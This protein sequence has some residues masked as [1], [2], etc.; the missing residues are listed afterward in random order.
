VLGAF[1]AA[2]LGDTVFAAQPI[3]HDPDLVFRR[4]MP[5][6]RPTDVIHHLLGGLLGWQS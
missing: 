2:Q 1:L 4:E 6:G 3:Q 5:P